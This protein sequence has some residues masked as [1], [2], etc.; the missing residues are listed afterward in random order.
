MKLQSLRGNDYAFIVDL[1]K[2][3]ERVF[4]GYEVEKLIASTIF[5]NLFDGKGFPVIPAY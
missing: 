5:K 1:A 4:A 2:D 3:V